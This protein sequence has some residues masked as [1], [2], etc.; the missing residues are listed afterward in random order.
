[1]MILRSSQSSMPKSANAFPRSLTS[2]SFVIDL[3]SDTSSK[4]S[5]DMK[6]AI[7]T[8]EV[9]DEGRRRK[10][11]IQYGDCPS[12]NKLQDAIAAK[13]GKEAAFLAPT[14]TQANQLMQML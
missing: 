9:G 2:R 3:R 12:T 11:R 10:G 4:I 1:M 8:S 13:F 14:Q 5:L 7:R 6:E